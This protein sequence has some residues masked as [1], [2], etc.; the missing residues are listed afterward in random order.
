MSWNLIP[1]SSDSVNRA[2]IAKISDGMRHVLASA[3]LSD[4]QFAVGQDYGASK[5]FLAHRLILSS[6]SDVFD[7]MFYGSVPENCADPIDIPDIHPEAFAN[8]LSYI[9]TD[10]VKNFTWENVFHIMSCADKYDLPLLV[11]SCANFIQKKL[12]YYKAAFSISHTHSPS[13]LCIATPA[14][15]SGHPY[16][17]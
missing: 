12:D 13:L 11:A 15:H 16:N 3:D 9:Y 17:P 4:V 1:P 8:M 10:A 6:R 5:T 14:L 2:G 7:T